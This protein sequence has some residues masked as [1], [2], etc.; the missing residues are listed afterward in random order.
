[1]KSRIQK[2]GPMTARMEPVAAN[3][4]S[5]PRGG[6]IDRLEEENAWLRQ[7]VRDLREKL[8]EKHQVIDRLYETGRLVSECPVFVG[9]VVSHQRASPEAG[10]PQESPGNGT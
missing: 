7:Q 5:P 9:Y 10:Q 4:F 1:M 3:F 8:R 2:W 6:T